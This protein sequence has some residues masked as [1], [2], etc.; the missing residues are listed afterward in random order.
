VEVVPV[1]GLK[2]SAVAA[3]APTPPPARSTRPSARVAVAGE[4]RGVVRGTPGVKAPVAGLKISVL[5][6]VFVPS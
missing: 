1:A 6:R 2:I 3:S 4:Y 5:C